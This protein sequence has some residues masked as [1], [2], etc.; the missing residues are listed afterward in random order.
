MPGSFSHLSVGA[1]TDVGVRRKKN[2]DSILTLPTHGV[3]CVADGMGGAQGGE[4]ASQAAVT[5]LKNAFDALSSPDAVAGA[6][7]KARLIDRALNEASSWIK[8]R[9]DKKGIKGAGTTAVVLAFDG[10]RPEKALV[11]HAGDSRAYRLR[12]EKLDQLSRDHT[13][14][15]AAGITDDSKLPS[16]FKGVVTRAVGVNAKVELEVTPTDVVE[17]DL[18]LL[19]SD[20][21]DKLVPDEDIRSFLLAGGEGDLQVLAQKLVD[22][23]NQRGGVD[24]VSVIVIR[25]GKA[26]PAT[27]IAGTDED[28]DLGPE[29]VTLG[30]DDER[31]TGAD[32]RPTDD[33]DDYEGTTPSR[34]AFPEG[35]RAAVAG[36]RSASGSEGR[37]SF[38]QWIDRH[39]N[40]LLLLLLALFLS[41]VL[42]QLSQ[43]RN[44][45]A[46]PP[47]F[48]EGLEEFSNSGGELLVPKPPGPKLE[49]PVVE[50]PAAALLALEEALAVEAKKDKDDRDEGASPPPSSGGAE[51]DLDEGAV[52]PPPEM[53]ADPGVREDDRA[54]APGEPADAV[55]EPDTMVA[56]A[57]AAADRANERRR[58]EAQAREQ[59]EA[60]ARSASEI[61]EALRAAGAG[62]A[63]AL[64]QVAVSLQ[65]LA[66]EAYDEVD[67]SHRQD[68][69]AQLTSDLVRA[70][71]AYLETRRADLTSGLE[72][73]QPADD[74]LT[75]FDA[76][77]AE[78]PRLAAMVRDPYREARDAVE[79]AQ[80]TWKGRAL[81]AQALERVDQVLPDRIDS[82]E[83]LR[84]AESAAQV[85]TTAAARRWEGVE[86]A[87]KAERLGSRSVVLTD[88]VTAYVEARRA[89]TVEVLR[90]GEAEPN[91]GEDL[92]TLRDQAPGA[93][94]L[95][96]ETLDRALTEI[97]DVRAELE[98]ARVAA[99]AAARA[100]AE[101]RAAEAADQA[102]ETFPARLVEVGESGAWGA[103]SAWMEEWKEALG[104]GTVSEEHA[105]SI[106]AW[107]RVWTEA[108][109]Q[110]D[111]LPEE[112][113]EAWT[114]VA[115]LG[116]S[117][118]AAPLPDLPP[119]PEDPARRADAYCA[120]RS[121]LERYLAGP[122]AEAAR[123][124]LPAATD[125]A[126][127]TGAA[128]A[129][130]FTLCGRPVEPARAAELSDRL[131]GNDDNREAVVE[132]IAG[133]P[134]G[135]IPLAVLRAGPGAEGAMDM[136]ARGQAWEEVAELV[137]GPLLAKIDQGLVYGG[138]LG[139]DLNRDADALRAVQ[140]LEDAAFDWIEARATIGAEDRD[141]WRNR[142]DP[143]LW[144]TLKTQLLAVHDRIR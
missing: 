75:R 92:A 84:A 3:Y 81:F 29:P 23:T 59:R 97:A 31:A 43:L 52:L 8:R 69:E 93:A 30:D 14:A 45:P 61:R 117:V 109:D 40:R 85:L 51:L 55:V 143:N 1:V 96:S 77:P 35:R 44:R 39:G 28:D 41:V 72:A 91:T 86:D 66:G 123:R 106:E 22:V 99:M 88:R 130:L 89:R 2:E 112:L 32:G 6:P 27:L 26:D 4:V 70:G 107:T 25:V 103:L 67:A 13:V 12:R 137:D 58:R 10:R 94:A 74:I 121:Q 134:P 57:A 7:A 138:F 76:F 95:A 108:R 17:G 64:E 21:L 78:A 60:Y 49:E 122:V 144:E 68:V 141:P 42:F 136:T 56:E 100:E 125:S 119:L 11:V 129:A 101:A 113:S 16:M 127:Q 135:P 79:R 82:P 131:Q 128:I 114:A 126:A 115:G 19:A 139:L 118:A 62:D 105:R 116:A 124:P 37:F 36:R 18:F 50:D 46:R 20:G 34:G 73:G 54:S 38:G 140:A 102:R 80:R 65:A 98:A 120:A 53:E 104:D 9:S 63:G 90:A 110:P 142:A 71:S 48:V 132:W 5:C 15:E 133:L 33:A 111:R 47:G 24:N 87:E 83:S